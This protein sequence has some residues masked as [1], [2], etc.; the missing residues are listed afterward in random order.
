VATCTPADDGIII[1]MCMALN[2]DDPGVVPFA[3][4]QV[5]RTLV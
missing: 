3:P 5:M 2:I 4:A 1:E